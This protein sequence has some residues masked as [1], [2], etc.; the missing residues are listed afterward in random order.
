MREKLKSVLIMVLMVT[1]LCGCANT[2][3]EPGAKK[4]EPL[5]IEKDLSETA[6]FKKEF[7]KQL[8]DKDVSLT[9]YVDNAEDF[10]YKGKLEVVQDGLDGRELM[11]FIYADQKS[12]ES[13][14]F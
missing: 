11:L 4:A 9:V 7:Y 14:W 10:N 6:E 2:I 3:D 13:D 8:E 1:T 5:V 12:M